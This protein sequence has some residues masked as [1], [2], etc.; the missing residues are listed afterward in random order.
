MLKM[1]LPRHAA[2]HHM[3]AAHLALHILQSRML[4]SPQGRDPE[5]TVLLTSTASVRAS[6]SHSTHQTRHDG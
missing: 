4:L 6:K 2:V 1:W 5:F 3:L